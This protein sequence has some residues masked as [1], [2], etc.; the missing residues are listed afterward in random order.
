MRDR[1][2]N[3]HRSAPRLFGWL[4]VGVLALGVTGCVHND[5]LV[6]GATE[7]WVASDTH[8][9]PKSFG[10]VFTSVFD[11]ILAPWFMMGEQVF[12]DE[13][14]HPDH[15]YIS[16]SGS[17]TVARSDMAQGYQFVASVFSIPIDT[18]YL[19]LTGPIDLIWV[20]AS[21]A[22]TTMEGEEG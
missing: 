20:L 1:T 3:T 2:P 10:V 9:I 19:L 16:Y 11:A 6:F 18:V 7:K 8:M 17:R 22:D 14:Y 21:D 5:H 12:R 13:Q 15:K 4:L